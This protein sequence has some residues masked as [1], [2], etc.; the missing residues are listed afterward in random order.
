MLKGVNIKRDGQVRSWH[1]NVLGFRKS[2]EGE[3][4][5]LVEEETDKKRW[6]NLAT[7]SGVVEICNRGGVW[8][9]YRYSNFPT[10]E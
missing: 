6:C 4:M 8:K 5:V 1:G 9:R 10:P 2:A 3:L 7:F